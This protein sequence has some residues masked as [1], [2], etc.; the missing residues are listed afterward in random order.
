MKNSLKRDAIVHNYKI[1]VKIIIILILIIKI[2]SI[3]NILKNKYFTI[4]NRI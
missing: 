4:R 2:I 3:N 1:E